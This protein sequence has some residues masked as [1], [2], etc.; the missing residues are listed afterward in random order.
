M[1]ALFVGITFPMLLIAAAFKDATTMTIPNPISLAL[2]AAFVVAAPFCLAP[3]AIG[4]H[5]GVAFG[6]LVIG[7][8]MFALNWVGGGDAKLLAAAALWMGW[9]ALPEF[10]MWTALAG[11]GLSLTLLLARKAALYAPF[12]T[13]EG[14]LARLLEPKGDIPYGLAIAAGGLAAFPAS[15]V[16]VGALG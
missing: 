3:A 7:F 1:L 2:A 10:L 8:V 16:F 5:L 13:G 4:V 15:G 11:G 14:A 12:A 9:S 6:V